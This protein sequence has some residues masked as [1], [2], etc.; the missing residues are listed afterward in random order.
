[1][2]KLTQEAIA[3]LNLKFEGAP[4]FQR[5][6]KK[7]R[8]LFVVEGRAAGSIRILNEE[9]FGSFVEGRK[10]FMQRQEE[11]RLASEY[12]AKGRTIGEARRL[13]REDVATADAPVTSYV[14]RGPLTFNPF[15]TL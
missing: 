2:S 7:E 11:R 8:S 3:M 15:A 6:A 14:A 13:A 9:G 4:S 10:E 12:V 1:M 5:T